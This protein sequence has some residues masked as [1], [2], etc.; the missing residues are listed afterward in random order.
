MSVGERVRWWG[1]TAMVGLAALM[2]TTGACAPTLA[3]TPPSAPADAP[4]TS[5]SSP[6][7]GPGMRAPLIVC[8]HGSSQLVTAP[9]QRPPELCLRVGATITVR[10]TAMGILRV[11][12]T[13]PQVATATVAGEPAGGLGAVVVHAMAPGTTRIDITVATTAPSV[14]TVAV[15]A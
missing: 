10:T 8:R 4:A 9:A 13:D 2:A 1:P 14:L 6:E 11:A 3:L 15:L 5:P 12:D 7:A